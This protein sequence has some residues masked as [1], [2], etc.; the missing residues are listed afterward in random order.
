MTKQN[1][2]KSFDE[3]L[4]EINKK[5]INNFFI[6]VYFVDSNVNKIQRKIYRIEL[7]NNVD[8][9]NNLKIQ[10]MFRYKFDY[11]DISKSYWTRM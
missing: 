3:S 9:N 7:V 10:T 5:I 4:F 2:I 1:Q 8:R 11:N 6:F